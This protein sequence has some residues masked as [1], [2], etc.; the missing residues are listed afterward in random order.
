MVGGQLKVLMACC[1]GIQ[2]PE[3]D[4]EVSPVRSSSPTRASPQILQNAR[5]V[6]AAVEMHQAT[7]STPLLQAMYLAM[8]QIVAVFGADQHVMDA[9]C[10]FID[11]TMRSPV[12]LLHMRF[13]NVRMFVMGTFVQRHGDCFHACIVDT[14]TCL[15]CVFGE[16]MRGSEFV[17]P[18][19]E[20]TYA[21]ADTVL[22]QLGSRP[23]IE[24]HSDVVDSFFG[25]VTRLV[26]FAPAVLYNSF[27]P[28]MLERIL[29]FAVHCLRVQERLV[30]KATIHFLVCVVCTV[31]RGG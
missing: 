13:D 25:F 28:S 29:A 18:L 20:M 7:A 23:H 16:H 27:P 8:E 5:S 11:M 30:L 26:R 22:T 1:R 2:A 10:A 24:S 4:D 31:R 3:T 14:A 19:R 6:E 12:H 9:L 17:V 21:I 15:V